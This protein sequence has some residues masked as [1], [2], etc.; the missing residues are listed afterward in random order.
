MTSIA[1]RPLFSRVV[2]KALDLV[3]PPRCVSCDA[4]GAFFCHHCIENA[5]R[6]GS[7]RCPRCWMPEP[8]EAECRRCRARHPAFSGVRSVFVYDGAARDAVHAIK[9]RGV[10]ALAPVMG[11][12]MAEQLQCWRPDIGAIVPVPLA[13]HRD[14]TR[15]YNQSQLL[16]RQLARLSG[17]P[18]DSRALVRRRATAPQARQPGEQARHRNVAGAFSAGP[19]VPSGGILLIDDV[20]TTGATLDACARV[21]LSEG[22]GPVFALTFARED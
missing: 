13:R 21:L 22:A 2:E 9:F 12:L 15:G 1:R 10:S 18:L 8:R 7:P 20:V 3:F 5:A 6:A 19:R 17:V 16:A 4:F 11:S 14:R